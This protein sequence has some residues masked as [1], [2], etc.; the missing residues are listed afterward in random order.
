MK[1]RFIRLSYFIW[2][3]VPAGL[4]AAQLTAGLPAILW[5]YEFV[6]SGNRYIP[7]D[8]RY[9]TSCTFWGPYGLHKAPA[10]DGRCGVIRFF[11]EVN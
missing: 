2:L 1:P 11:K 4:V 7:F 8:E 9:F 5:R 3:I 6:S 10:H